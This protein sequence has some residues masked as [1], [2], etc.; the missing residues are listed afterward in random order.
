MEPFECI[1]AHVIPAVVQFILAA[2]RFQAILPFQIL[3]QLGTSLILPG[4][5]GA[6]AVPV[7][8][9]IDISARAAIKLLVEGSVCKC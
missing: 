5:I 9:G 4:D 7:C 6:E 2:H 8:V 3:Q 1:P